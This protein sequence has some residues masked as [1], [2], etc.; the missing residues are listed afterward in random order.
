[1]AAA[2]PAAVSVFESPS[3]QGDKAARKILKTTY[4]STHEILNRPKT[5]SPIPVSSM[6]R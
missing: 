4:S 2:N 5:T 3:A 1:M 6:I